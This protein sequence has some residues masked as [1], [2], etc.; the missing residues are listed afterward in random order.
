MKSS[1]GV[2]QFF[3]SARATVKHLIGA[4]NNAAAAGDNQIFA[5]LLD[6]HVADGVVDCKGFKSAEAGLDRYL[7]LP[8]A[9]DPAARNPADRFAFDAWAYD[10][11]TL[12]LIRRH[13]PGIESIKRRPSWAALITTS[14]SSVVVL[15]G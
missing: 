2:P 6:Q 5:R 15:P 12:K 7:A 10:A 13:D 4:A 14:A 3:L 9:V 1:L 8:T 11:R